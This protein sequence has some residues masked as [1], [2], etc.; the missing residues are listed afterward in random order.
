MGM[1][2]NKLDR[3]IQFRRY[4]ETQ[5]PFGTVEEWIDHG[6]QVWAHRSDIKDSEKIQAGQV[7]AT[8]TTRFTVRSSEFTRDINAKDRIKHA[9]LTFDIQGVKESADGRL[10]FLEL[11]ASARADA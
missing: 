2:V 11:T 8:L 3:R 1:N 9:G 10:Q 5:G 7:L 4:T 6:L